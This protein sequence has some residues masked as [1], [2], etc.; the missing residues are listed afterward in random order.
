MNQR[1]KKHTPS[2]T[3]T[4]FFLIM[5]KCFNT[6]YQ[7]F[8]NKLL[9]FCCQPLDM[10]EVCENYLRDWV[11]I[12]DTQVQI[13]EQLAQRKPY[14]SGNLF[15]MMEKCGRSTVLLPQAAL[16]FIGLATGEPTIL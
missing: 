8:S 15:C 4:T 5:A 10:F 1:F 11:S 9:F 6:M 7:M 2:S 3:A 12:S 16:D 13:I 14:E